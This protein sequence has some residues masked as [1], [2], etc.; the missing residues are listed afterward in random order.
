MADVQDPAIKTKLQGLHPQRPPVNLADHGLPAGIQVDLTCEDK[1]FS[2]ADVTW[3]AAMS[4]PPGS[5][6]GPS[7]L[8]PGHLK[9][10]LLKEGR[11]G[12]L[13]AALQA[14]VE[15][16]CLGLL[17]DELAPILCAATLIPLEK[18]VWRSTPNRRGKAAFD[19][20]INR[21]SIDTP[22]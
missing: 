13:H 19:Q 22:D 4:F 5:A 14:L 10:L 1:D 18:T 3:E 6:P 7:G 17:P 8:R 2:W 20:S 21:L 15:G 9:D 11:G 12:G 16:G